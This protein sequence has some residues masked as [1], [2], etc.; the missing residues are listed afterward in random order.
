[1]SVSRWP[2]EGGGEREYAREYA[3]E[4]GGWEPH[5]EGISDMWLE[6]S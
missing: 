6:N 1:M 2:G 5:D 3:P 4:L